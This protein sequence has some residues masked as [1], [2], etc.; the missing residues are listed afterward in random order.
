MASKHKNGIFL[1]N[2]DGPQLETMI[3]WLSKIAQPTLVG[4][5]SYPKDLVKLVELLEM[6]DYYDIP[7]FKNELYEEIAQNYA[8]RRYTNV[9]RLVFD[10]LGEDRSLDLLSQ[11]SFDINL[12]CFTLIDPT[13]SFDGDEIISLAIQGE[14]RENL[15]ES[16]RLDPA[17]FYPVFLEKY[18]EYTRDRIDFVAGT[19]DENH[20][21]CN[22]IYD[23]DVMYLTKEYL[24]C[25]KDT[26]ED[27][28]HADLVVSDLIKFLRFFRIQLSR[29][30]FDFPACFY[31]DS[32]L[33]KF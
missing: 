12:L 14:E 7:R 2:V 1:E 23:E 4:R 9:R 21:T 26:K 19:R 33:D 18:K 22:F 8:F 15:Q 6:A 32:A 11:P 17:Q 24:E 30:S 10:Y 20:K 27:F 5:K 13:I 3:H 16:K 29:I 31:F 28:S 25:Y